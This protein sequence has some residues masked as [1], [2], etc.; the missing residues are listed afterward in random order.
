MA[1]R[2][3]VVNDTQEILD[4]FRVMLEY[5]GYEVVL[6]SFPFKN[7]HDIEKIEPDLVILDFIFGNERTGWQMLE[8]LKMQ[9]STTPIPVIVC[10]GAIHEVQEQ[11]SYLVSQGVHVVYKPFDIDHLLTIISQA[12]ASHKKTISQAKED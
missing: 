11:E 10:T 8:L 4:L 12:L 3:L 7:I 2:I 9:R 6:S 1:T 5:E